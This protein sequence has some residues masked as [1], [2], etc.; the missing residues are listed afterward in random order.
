MRTS[1]LMRPGR[2]DSTATRFAMKIASSMSCV[3]KST[4]LRSAS[5]MP[6]KSSC[7]SERGALLHAAGEHLRIVPLEAAQPDACDELGCALRRCARAKEDV[8]LDCEPGEER[9]GL[10]YH[11]AVGTGACDRLAIEK[12][13]PGARVLESGDDA[14][15]RSEERR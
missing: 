7:M 11:A 9:V 4:V 3:T 13:A 14:T 2:A 5:Q 6:S 8:L 12:Y 1:A 10:E 15:E